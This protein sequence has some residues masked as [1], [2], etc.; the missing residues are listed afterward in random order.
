MVK[1]CW[2]KFATV[3]TMAEETFGVKNVNTLNE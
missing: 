1:L 2:E 3:Y